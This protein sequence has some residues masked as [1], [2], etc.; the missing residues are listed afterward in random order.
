M[1]ANNC[2]NGMQLATMLPDSSDNV[3]IKAIVP[4]TILELLR[5]I[6]QS[7]T[8][9]MSM[10]RTTCGVLAFYFSTSLAHLTIQAVFDGKDSFRAYLVGRKYAE[11]SVRT[12]VNQVRILLKAAQAFGWSPVDDVPESWESVMAAAGKRKIN[13]SLVQHLMKVRSTPLEVTAD[14]AAQWARSKVQLGFSVSNT[15]RT[16]GWLRHTLN[17]LGLAGQDAWRFA[18]TYQVG[19]SEFPSKLKSEVI[20]LL[21]WKQAEFSPGRPSDGQ[22]RPVTAKALS[23]MICRLYGFA[24]RIAGNNEIK[25]L[26]DLV[27]EKTL[28]DFVEWRINRRHNN[29]YAVRIG[30][31]MLWAAL[32]HHPVHRN[33]DL[34]WFDTLIKSVA[35]EPES[36]RRKKKAEKYLEYSVVE[37]IPERIRQDRL[38][39]RNT[40][41]QVSY[42]VME[43]LLIKWLVILPWRQRNLR[44]CRI[45]GP[46]PNL[47]KSKIQPLSEVKKPDWVLKEEQQNPSAQFW[48]FHFRS[49][50]TKTGND[51]HSL[52]PKQLVPLLEEYLSEHRP[53]LLR[54]HHCDN[55]FLNRR[56]GRL[57]AGVMSRL[58]RE[59]T[60][61]YAG[62]QIT[63]HRFR[64]IV[65]YAWLEDHP[66][67][68]VRLSKLLWH[69]NLNTTLRIYGARFNEASGV[70]AMEAWLD[71]R[72]KRRN[73]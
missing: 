17:R 46:D 69:R 27:Q 30:L 53:H 63:P 39:L 29:G 54:G 36:L 60:L 40:S 13:K 20:E 34:A 22:H 26:S 65:A 6:E 32:R 61:R 64:D 18:T 4:K 31:A 8:T 2:P 58:V 66:E 68:Y 47:F 56:G 49:L 35:L 67:D 43:E 33:M 25:C 23:D 24:S 5:R 59:L 48:Q 42:L 50:E 41:G 11:N 28:T 37:T 62:R 45:S 10:L 57:D 12:Y 52:L 19:V 1:T 9:G 15:N 51:V 16:I 55:L 73:D 7:G 38:K 14:D 44:E 71:E 72:E 21:R 70:C 3:P